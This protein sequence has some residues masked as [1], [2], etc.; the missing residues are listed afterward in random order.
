MTLIPPPPRRLPI[1][2]RL[3]ERQ[4]LRLP[5]WRIRKVILGGRQRRH[6]PK[7]L[8]IIPQ[9]QRLVRGLVVDL[10]ADLEEER[11]CGDGVVAAV[12]GVVPV[13]DQGAEHGAGFP[14]VVG[15]GEEAR[16]L[17]GE[18]AAVEGDE[19]GGYCG[20]GGADGVWMVLIRYVGLFSVYGQLTWR[21]DVQCY[22]CCGGT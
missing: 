12:A 9:L 10:V 13:V 17:A 18:V 19:V 15:E 4:P 16:G 21:V 8:V 1:K 2:H 7:R 6:S 5:L 14:P 11:L 20:G 3:T 22:G